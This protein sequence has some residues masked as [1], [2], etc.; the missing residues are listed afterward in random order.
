MCAGGDSAGF[1]GGVV[2]SGFCMTLVHRLCKEDGR[3]VTFLY[4][5]M[6]VVGGILDVGNHEPVQPDRRIECFSEDV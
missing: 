4:E 2:G 6:E 3:G 5:K 1:G